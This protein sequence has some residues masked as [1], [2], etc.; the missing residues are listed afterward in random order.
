MQDEP[1]DPRQDLQ[2]PRQ[3]LQDR[4]DEFHREMDRLHAELVV[5]INEAAARTRAAERGDSGDD[6]IPPRLTS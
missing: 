6:G 1:K 3:D 4:L 5:H 2:K